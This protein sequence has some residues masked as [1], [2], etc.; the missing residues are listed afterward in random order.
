MGNVDLDTR[1]NDRGRQHEDD[2][3]YE[4]HVDKR[5]D[6]DLRERTLGAALGVSECHKNLFHHGATEDTEK[7]GNGFNTEAKRAESVLDASFE[8]PFFGCDIKKGRI[9]LRVSRSSSST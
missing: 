2:E 7:R 9:F 8:L 1:L 6:V 3:Q 5:C 4:H